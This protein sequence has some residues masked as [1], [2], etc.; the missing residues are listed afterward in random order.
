MAKLPLTTVQHVKVS[1]LPGVVELSVFMNK[2]C[3]HLFHCVRLEAI[4]IRLEATASRLEAMASRSEAIA[5]RLE[6]S[7]LGWRQ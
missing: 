5:S 7:L 2:S 4:A 3:C 1:T 6:P